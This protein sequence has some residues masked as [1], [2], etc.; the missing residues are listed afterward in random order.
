MPHT[1]VLLIIAVFVVGVL[2]T[3]V[4]DHWVP[5]TLIARQRGWSMSQVAWAAAGAGLGHTVS[6]LLIAVIVWTAGVAVAAR[7]GNIVNVLTSLALI[8]FGLWVALGAVKELQ[9]GGCDNR[10][11]HGHEHRH[12]GH[13][14]AHRHEGHLAHTHWHTHHAEDWHSIEGNIALAPPMHH[15]EHTTSARTALLLVLGSS[16]MVEG[17]PAFFA[18]AKYGVGL[19]AIM[20]IVF[21]F[22]TIGTYVLLCVGSCTGLQKINLGP[23]ERYGEVG[24]GVFIAIL[25]TVF[26]FIH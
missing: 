6:T 25:G 21:A 10:V 4:P 14:H 1:A 5:I 20:S 18:A 23:W 24:S 19:L 17:I 16:P 11:G 9:N 7:F 26:L 8:G 22:S 13:T 12:F 3:L 15:H 2:H